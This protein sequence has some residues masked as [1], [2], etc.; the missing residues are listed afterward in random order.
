MKFGGHETFPLRDNWLF[1]GM[2]FLKMRGDLFADHQQAIARL[3][4]GKN[5]VKSIRHWLLATGFACLIDNRLSPSVIG[6]LVD[7]Y[8][9]YYDRLGS[10]WLIHYLLVCNKDYA[11]TWYWFFNKFAAREFT[12]ESAGQHLDNFCKIVG[13]KVSSTTLARDLSVLLRMYTESDFQ[14]NK[15]PEDLDICPLTRLSLLKKQPNNTFQLINPKHIP[16]EIFGYALICFWQQ[17][18]PKVSQFS[19]EELLAR[20]HAPTKVFCLSV[21]STVEMLD[22]LVEKFPN[23]F[24]YQQTAGVFVV[25]I[26]YKLTP[27]TMLQ[28]YY[29]R[30]F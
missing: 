23:W 19:F 25:E 2:Q 15:T 10:I 1:K 9:P 17:W 11:T 26:N 3:G 12:D 7:K 20:D 6:R 16:I 29:R 30:S 21:D 14:K 13:K 18:F 4:V 27:E 22:R 24:S 5:M 28:I 8:D